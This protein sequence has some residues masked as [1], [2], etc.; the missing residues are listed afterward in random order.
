MGYLSLQKGKF[1][2]I[3]PRA[4]TSL[5]IQ[6]SSCSKRTETNTTYCYCQFCQ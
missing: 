5:Q 6:V 1:I 3:K 2:G 4:V